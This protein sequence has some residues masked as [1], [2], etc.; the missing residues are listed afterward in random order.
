MSEP[1]DVRISARAERDLLRLPEKI[2]AACLA[3]M[4]GPLTEQPHRLG[5]ALRGQLAG[6]HSARR[7][8]YHI[9]YRIDH[10]Q[11]CVD[12]VHVAYRGDAYR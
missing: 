7:G 11:C 6:L 1:Y 2:A 9:S 8:S 4:F 10:H 12:I 3:F 5:G